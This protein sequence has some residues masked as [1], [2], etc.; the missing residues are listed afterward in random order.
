MFL[1]VKENSVAQKAETRNAQMIPIVLSQKI[2]KTEKRNYRYLMLYNAIYFVVCLL[3]KSVGFYSIILSLPER[4]Q[5]NQEGNQ[6]RSRIVWTLSGI[7][8]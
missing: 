3:V 2:P 7:V 8:N 4:I 5:P 1:F 6:P